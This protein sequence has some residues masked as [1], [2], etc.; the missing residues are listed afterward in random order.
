MHDP[1]CPDGELRKDGDKVARGRP[2]CHDFIKRTNEA[3]RQRSSDSVQLE[4][5]VAVKALDGEDCCMK[6]LDTPGPNEANAGLQKEVETALKQTICSFLQ[7]HFTHNKKSEAVNTFVDEYT[8]HLQL[9]MQESL[10]PGTASSSIQQLLI[11]NQ[12]ELLQ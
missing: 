8:E 7:S 12:H 2:A 11:F 9:V 3:R 6:L 10:V 5:R 1:E 4:L